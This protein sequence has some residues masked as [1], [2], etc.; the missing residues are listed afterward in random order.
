MPIDL[1]TTGEGAPLVDAAGEHIVAGNVVL[2]KSDAPRCLIIAL[3]DGNGGPWDS[4]RELYY[5]GE[6]L[7]TS[8]YHFHP[9][10]P[11][12]GVDDPV[13]GVDS[14]FP[15]GIP[16]SHTAYISVRLPDTVAEVDPAGVVGRYK[17][18]QLPDFDQDGQ[19]ITVGY[20]A[21]PARYAAFQMLEKAK[22]SA[23]RINWPSWCAWRDQCD[24]LIDWDDGIAATFRQIKRFEGHVAFTSAVDLSSALNLLTDLSAHCWQDDGEQIFFKPLYG[25]DI[26]FEFSENVNIVESSVNV[27]EIDVRTLPTRQIVRFRNL[28]NEYLQPASWPAKREPAIYQLGIRDANERSFG[29]MTYSQGQ[30]ISKFLLR[31]ANLSKR[32]ELRGDGST[33]A[34]LPGDVVRIIHPAVDNIRALV[35]ETED[36]ADSADTRRFVC[37]HLTADLYSDT[38]HEPIPK[39][40]PVPT[41]PVVP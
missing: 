31:L 28:D 19:Q 36:E 35:L 15:A 12:A 3:G 2:H 14:F 25:P 22:I 38:D 24:G 40:L 5:H 18:R 33:F 16:F 8:A 41:T 4:C 7:D 20:S 13:Q 10:T 26:D 1:L 17:T 9:G 37:A 23:T 11:S 39:Q 27:S 21:N 29:A 6:K 30:R 32:I 34:V